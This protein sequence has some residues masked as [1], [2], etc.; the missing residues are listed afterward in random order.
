MRDESALPIARPTLAALRAA[1]AE[2]PVIV[3]LKI[4]ER[5]DP[6]ER[7]VFHR[8]EL[9]LDYLG[10]VARP[11][12]VLVAWRFDA[13]CREDNVLVQAHAIHAD[14]ER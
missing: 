12:D 14:D 1:L 3:E 7:L 13:A 10:M 5:A 9:L 2:S 11:G 6:P 4:G 8:Y